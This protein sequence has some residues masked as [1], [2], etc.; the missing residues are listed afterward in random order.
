M[1]MGSKRSAENDVSNTDVNRRVYLRNVSALAGVASLGATGGC[2]SS[3]GD[4][5]GNYPS[6]DVEIIVPFATGG[7]FDAYTRLSESYWEDNLGG[8][9]VVSNVTGG[10]GINGAT[11]TYN[12]SPD[13]HTF[14]IWDVYQSLTQQMARDVE[15]DI[16]EMSHIGA[17]SQEPNA[18][19][20][21]DE[22][23][24]DNFD[25]FIGK[26][27]ELNFATQGSGSAAHTM[28]ALLTMFIDDVSPEDPNFV[29]FDGTGEVLGGLE[30]G[31]AEVFV[32][33]TV[34]SA[35]K[36]AQSLDG[37]SLFTVFEEEEEIGGYLDGKGITP[38]HYSPQLEIDGMEEYNQLTALRRFFTG[39][40]DVPDDVLETQRDAFSEMINNDEFITELEESNRPA[41]NPGGADVVQDR[42]DQVSNTLSEDQ[43][44]SLLDDLF[45]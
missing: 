26:M 13:G 12:A 16:L 3:L 29:H 21:T 14:M 42:L 32:V 10:G 36:T 33:S 44:Q 30:R 6:Q 37:A 23:D 41:L 15:F 27:G 35:A 40:P 7:G 18:M 38:T 17:I 8:E 34:T 4:D 20:V 24:V 43:Y 1:T 5:G 22:A 31:E 11:K 28:A 45:S 39:P 25:D 9:V 19:V 2:L